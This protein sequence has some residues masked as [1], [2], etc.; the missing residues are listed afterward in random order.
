MMFS[1]TFSSIDMRAPRPIL[2]CT[3][4]MAVTRAIVAV[5]CVLFVCPGVPKPPTPPPYVSMRHVRNA[6]G[7]VGGRKKGREARK[8]KDRNEDWACSE[9]HGSCVCVS[10]HYLLSILNKKITPC[11]ALDE[12]SLPTLTHTPPF[13]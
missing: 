13:L 3:H 6:V 2:H 1:P 11:C 12:G 7:D 4:T 5:L 10:A 8:G 9:L